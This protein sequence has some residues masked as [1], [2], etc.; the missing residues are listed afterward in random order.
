M[1]ITADDFIIGKIKG[2]T[3]QKKGILLKI[4]YLLKIFTFSYKTKLW[5][6]SGCWKLRRLNHFRLPTFKLLK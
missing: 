2:K 6:N 4:K 1:R 5:L 3:I